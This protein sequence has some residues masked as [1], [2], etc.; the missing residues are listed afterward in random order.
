VAASLPVERSITGGRSRARFARDR[1]A[2]I[3]Y[4]LPAWGLVVA[5]IAVPLGW[6]VYLS[7]RNEGLAIFS[8]SRFVGLANYDRLIHDTDF[9]H[10]AKVTLLITLLDIAIQL[11]IGLALAL[12]LNRELRGTKLF[13]SAL[14]LPM[15]LTPVAVGLMWR[16]MFN[17]D[18][19]VINWLIG[20]LGA[21]RIDWLGGHT[22]AL[23]SI[24]IVDS[25]QSIPFVML[26]LLAGLQSM[27]L[28][29]HEA[30][31]VDGAS[32]YQTFR[33]VTAPLLAPV[34][35]IILMIRLIEGVKLFDIIYI[36]TQGGPGTATQNVSLLAY[37]TGFS[38]LATSRSAA[39]GV[40]LLIALMPLYFLWLKASRE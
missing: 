22:A 19:G 29:P 14:L 12:A 23:F 18:L 7:V 4:V 34:V 36:V 17:S 35:L 8:H 5:A 33:Y 40:V 30:S 26:M 32:P 31:A 27:P 15:M 9:W 39:I 38:F 16:F 24:V 3:V 20:E 25:W 11:P 37:R 1:L 2:P 13:R 10:A 28:S 6:G 21:G